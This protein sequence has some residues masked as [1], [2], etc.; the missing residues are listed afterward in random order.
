M[1]KLSIDAGKNVLV[2]GILLYGFGELLFKYAITQLLPNE[3]ALFV[4][5][6]IGLQFF[7]I[8]AI[9]AGVAWVIG[10]WLK[11]PQVREEGQREEENQQSE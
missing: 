3:A 5:G 2:I 10:G 6:A 4:Y 8:L 1:D 7:G 9:A 11:A